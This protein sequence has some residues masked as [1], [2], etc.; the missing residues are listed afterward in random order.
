[1]RRGS[2]RGLSGWDLVVAV[3]G[4]GIAWGLA[5]RHHYSVGWIVVAC[6][7]TALWLIGFVRRLLRM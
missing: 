7:L 2:G 4:I 6:I 3:L 5:G 1:M